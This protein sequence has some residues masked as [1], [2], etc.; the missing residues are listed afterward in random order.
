[1][2]LLLEMTAPEVKVL[3]EEIDEKTGDKTL[4][5]QVKWQEADRING[6]GRRYPRAILQR[7][8]TRLAPEIKRGAVFACGYHP[9]DEAEVADVAALW[10]SVEMKS[11]GQCLGIVKILPTSRG[12]DAQVIIHAGGHIGM[13]S[14]GYGTVTPKEE[15]DVHTGK[16]VR[17]DEVNPD[18]RLK[19]PGDFV[20]NPSVVDSGVVG[21]FEARFKDEKVEEP[22]LESFSSDIVG[23]LDEAEQRKRAYKFYL[24]AKSSG[25]SGDFE[26]Y[27]ATVGNPE[28]LK[29]QDKITKR[30]AE[31]NKAGSQKLTQ[32]EVYN[33]LDEKGEI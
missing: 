16:K 5:V 4:R 21:M 22:K 28:W 17:F 8:I 13:S 12:R 33:E 29:Q 31:A 30:I 27:L 1:M 24:E 3:S 32:A 20:L 14:R 7:E 2:K 11:D 9:K 10:E 23:R 6:N 18:Y 25:W 26:E 15:E 19:S